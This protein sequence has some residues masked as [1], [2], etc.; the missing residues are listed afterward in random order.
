MKTIE[1][2]DTG[3]FQAVLGAPG[4]SPEIPEAADVYGWL[5]GGWKLDV[6]HY[7]VVVRA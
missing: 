7:V 3:N 5:I 1:A 4:R 6:L 2:V